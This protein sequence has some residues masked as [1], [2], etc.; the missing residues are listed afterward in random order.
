MD[1]LITDRLRDN[2]SRLKLTQAAEVLESVLKR[3]ETEKSSY[4]SFWD[5]LLEEEV[6]AKEKRRVQ[7]A[8]KTAGLALCQNH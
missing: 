2:L 7:T 3:A 8:I 4:M 5:H 6:A 1:Q